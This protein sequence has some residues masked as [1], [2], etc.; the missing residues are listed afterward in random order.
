MGG[1]ADDFLNVVD[2][3]YV[4]DAAYVRPLDMLVKDQLNPRKNP[5]FEHGEGVLFCAYRG[6][7]CVG[8]VTAQLDREHL[9]RYQ[10]DTGFF[11]FLDTVDD[12]EV[13]SELL[14]RAEA[15]LSTKG[16][17]RARGPFDDEQPGLVAFGAGL[18]G[19]QVRRRLEIEHRRLRR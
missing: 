18:L 11:G 13:A 10:D 1:S 9:R 19:D 7:D 16:M 12:S 3:I 5:F 2:V 4:G 14:K 6:R 15:W 17:K 8:R